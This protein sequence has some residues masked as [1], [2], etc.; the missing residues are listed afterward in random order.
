MGTDWAHFLARSLR[1]YTLFPPRLPHESAG[2]A[3]GRRTGQSSIPPSSTRSLSHR[4]RPASL[5]LTGEAGLTFP[6][7]TIETENGT[8]YALWW[9]ARQG[10][11]CQDGLR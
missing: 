11:N 1:R 5:V 9:E 10:S 3:I 8:E 7:W 4:M 6:P 2:E